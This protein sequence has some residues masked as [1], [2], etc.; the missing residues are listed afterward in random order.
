MLNVYCYNNSNNN[1]GSKIIINKLNDID[2]K[3]NIV[4]SITVTETDYNYKDYEKIYRSIIN[5]NIYNAL[6]LSFDHT[7]SIASISA[8]MNLYPNLFVIWIDIDP[9]INICSEINNKNV[10]SHL[11]GIEKNKFDWIKNYLNFDKIIYFGINNISDSQKLFFESNNI[12][13]FTSN[14]INSNTI[15][16][17]VNEI[18]FLIKDYPTH[19]SFN[20]NAISSLYIDSSLSNFENGLDLSTIKYLFESLNHIVSLDIVGFDPLIGNQEKSIN[21]LIE[22]I[23]E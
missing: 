3:S 9:Y 6:Y 16:T 21:N 4:F 20:I 8:M 2:I 14:C 13:Y 7:I 19:V 17:I 15:K 18:L 12:K 1:L 11:T 22:L 5:S 10:I 23:T